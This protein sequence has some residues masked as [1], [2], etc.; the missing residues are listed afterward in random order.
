ME[1]LIFPDIFRPHVTAFFTGKNPGADVREIGR[2][3]KIK[4]ED[5]FMPVQKHTDKVLILEASR[6]PKIADAVVT[7]ET[8]VL[9]G[10][11]VADCV[12]I[13]VYDKCRGVSGAVHAGWRGTAE[14]ILK[15]TISAMAGR[16]SCG[17]EDLLVAVGPSIRGCCYEVGHEVAEKVN[18]ATGDGEYVRRKGEKYYLDL[19]AANRLQAL[20]VGVRE[21]NLWTSPDCTFSNPEIYC[22]YRFAKG[23]TG[24]QGGFIGKI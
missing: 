20:S 5:I 18:H 13:L 14:G 9:L 7:G 24:R 2:L 16:F 22:S 6:E 23:Q 1:R 19:S 21:E 11:Q 10:V 12:P 15:K 3:L 17:A 4:R 8:G